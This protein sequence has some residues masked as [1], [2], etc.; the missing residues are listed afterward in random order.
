MK[1]GPR[2][3]FA[4][5]RGCARSLEDN[6]FTV[7]RKTIW[8]VNGDLGANQYCAELLTLVVTFVCLSRPSEDGYQ[9]RHRGQHGRPDGYSS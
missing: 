3:N 2:C 7:G 8:A 1:D 9:G 5:G 6:Y 4:A